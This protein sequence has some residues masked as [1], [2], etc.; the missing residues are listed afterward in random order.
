MTTT[1]TIPLPSSYSSISFSD[2]QNNLSSIVTS[3]DF[4]SE[5]DVT[6][7]P[8]EAGKVILFTTTEGNSGKMITRNTISGYEP[9]MITYEVYSAGGT[10][11]KSADATINQTYIFDFETNTYPDYPYTNGDIQ[12][13]WQT[14]THCTF[15]ANNSAKFYEMP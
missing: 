4:V 10:L 8:L 1:T 13:N 2:I 3:G 11:L 6:S 9:L 14:T 5:T 7:N 12:W 15:R